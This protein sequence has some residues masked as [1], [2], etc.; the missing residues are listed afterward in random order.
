MNLNVGELAVLC[1]IAALSVL[2]AYG[3]GNILVDLIYIYFFPFVLLYYAGRV[4]YKVVRAVNRV[5]VRLGTE[6]VQPL[7]INSIPG[8]PSPTMLPTGSA[9]QGQPA[10]ASAKSTH[11]GL[12]NR[13]QR[14]ITAPFVRFSLLWCVLLLLS[15]NRK[16]LW[17]A[18]AIVLFHIG[19]ALIAIVGV[20]IFSTNWLSQLEDRIR[21][22]AEAWIENIVAA[23]ESAPPENLSQTV[24]ALAGL[25]FALA[26]L[27]NR[28]RVAQWA[29]FLG[30]LV[31]VAVYLY[32]ALLFSVAYCGVAKLT[33]VALSWSD[34]LVYSIFILFAYSDLPKNA[35]LKGLAGFHAL[36]VVG[37][38]LTTIFGYLQ[39]KLNSLYSIADALNSRLEQPD[40]RTKIVVMAEKLKPTAAGAASGNIRN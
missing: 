3:I 25:Q 11:S 19:R 29:M 39:R 28:Q 14:L 26:L 18:L 24:G 10:V 15:T 17:I 21:S 22:K 9:T 5:F 6:D 20:A 12:K 31:F 27:R 4:A 2:A 33:H 7:D 37:L 1:L 35:W 36:F 8:F 32:L 30:L 40:V 13:F 16:L 38:G 34:S 23:N